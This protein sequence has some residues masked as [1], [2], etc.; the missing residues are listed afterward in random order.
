MFNFGHNDSAT[1]QWSSFE[2]NDTIYDLSHL[3]A[4]KVVYIDH[5]KSAEYTFYVTYSHHCFTKTEEG[6]ND[7]ID[8]RFDHY[9]DPRHFHPKRY[10]LSLMLPEIIENLPDKHVYHAGYSKYACCEIED[11]DGN[12]VHYQVVFE[13]FRSVKKWR[14]HISSAYPLNTRPKAKP[15]KFIKIGRA[16]ASGNKLPGPGRR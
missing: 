5:E 4:K 14:L 9:K 16:M 8:F 6:Y 12:I 11:K 3:N 13:V 2:H 1:Q 15:V 10:N 7:A